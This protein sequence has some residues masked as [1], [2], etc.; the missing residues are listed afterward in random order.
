MMLSHS[1]FPSSTAFFAA[2]SS[3][4]LMLFTALFTCCRLT[5]LFSPPRLV[6]SLLA[7]SAVFAVSFPRLRICVCV[8]IIAV[9]AFSRLCAIFWYSL[10][11]GSTPLRTRTCRALFAWST[12]FFCASSFCFSRSL[13]VAMYCSA[14]PLAFSCAS[15]F[16]SAASMVFTLC[17]ACCIPCLNW[18]MPLTPILTLTS[19]IVFHLYSN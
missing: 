7:F 12:S 9:S 14:F 19:G 18:L 16:L 3:P 11:A 13:L 2:C 17:C 1:C 10:L 4:P 6:S 5:F 8:S 15:F